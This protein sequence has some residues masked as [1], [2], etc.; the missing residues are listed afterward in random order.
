MAG[1]G[2]A[3]PCLTA[4]CSAV[5]AAALE[6]SS[7][8]KAAA[9]SEASTDG[10]GEGDAVALADAAGRAAAVLAGG[11]CFDRATPDATPTAT[12]TAAATT[13]MSLGTRWRGAEG[14]RSGPFGSSM[15]LDPVTGFGRGSAAAGTASA[16]GTA[17]PGWRDEGAGSGPAGSPGQ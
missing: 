7:V 9:C 13:R 5:R 2:Q 10:E 8:L 1:L 4:S 3:S 15:A 12:T 11:E 6:A 14:S 16:A 17:W